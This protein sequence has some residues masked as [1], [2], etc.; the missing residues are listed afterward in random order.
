MNAVRLRML[1]RRIAHPL[2]FLGWLQ[3]RAVR[4]LLADGSA[5]AVQ[6]LLE[7][8]PRLD[9]RELKEQL[10]GGLRALT[11]AEGRSV[12]CREWA[13]EGAPKLAELLRGWGWV[14]P[15]PARVRV[16]CALKLGRL[17]LLADGGAEEVAHLLAACGH[18]DPEVAARAPQALRNL[19]AAAAREAV[20]R[21]AIEQDDRQAL[22]AAL[23]AGYLPEGAERRAL[24]LFLTGR[25]EEY[26]ALDFDRALLRAAYQKARPAVRRRVGERVRQSGRADLLPV[27]TGS[28]AVPRRGRLS[29][30]EWLVTLDL[31]ARPGQEERLWELTQ[32]AP[33]WCGARALRLLRARGWPPAGAEE[34]A[35]FGALAELAE[36]LTEVDCGRFSLWAG[37]KEGAG[38]SL[39]ADL[40]AVLRGHE[41]AV[42]G[43]AVS[44]DGRLLASAGEDGK[45]CLWALPE[46]RPL[47]TFD[48]G[49]PGQCVLFGPDGEEVVSAHRD[50]RGHVWPVAGGPALSLA[51]APHEVRCLALSPDG[52]LLACDFADG[53]RVW[54]L[55]E[56]RVLAECQLAQW[57]RAYDLAVSPDG[58]VLACLNRH[59]QGGTGSRLTLWEL[60]GGRL[61]ANLSAPGNAESLTFGAG[62]RALVLAGAADQ[63]LRLWDK[64]NARATGRLLGQVPGHRHWATWPDFEADGAGR[65]AGVAGGGEVRLGRLP[66]GRPLAACL[67]ATGRA[68]GAPSAPV[69]QPLQASAGGPAAGRPAR[70]LRVWAAGD[71]GPSATWEA[72]TADLTYLVAAP[73]QG[74]LAAGAQDG[75]V[76][77]WGLPFREEELGRLAVADMTLAHWDWVRGRLRD[78]TTPAA[79][80]RGLAFLDALLRRRWRHAVHVE[81]ARLTG[82]PHDILIEG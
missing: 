40:R 1:R 10:L 41:G 33:P 19:R 16:L 53:A 54:G 74:L 78:G 56:G 62:G 76:C 37:G 6:T 55:D 39:A 65:K 72:G 48:A 26:E 21:A 3:G 4:E 46:G 22:A 63:K 51:L 57:F 7:V 18:A 5:A 25:W 11:A 73:S 36:G 12:V 30:Q 52:T 27:L 64:T 44:P 77:L 75:G 70:S 34:R 29:E 42:R 80:R 69:A 71:S 2:P 49:S 20:C 24:F 45:V 59:L 66:D 14:P 32:A 28:A 9:T 35:D 58:A 8:L 13:R 81:E 23:G 31:L 15:A 61:R 60:P 17:D 82:G 79:E 47:H 50:G 67:H 43:L 38:R 68:A